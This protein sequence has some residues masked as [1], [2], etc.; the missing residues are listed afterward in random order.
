MVRAID[1]LETLG[2]GGISRGGYV[3]SKDCTK[4]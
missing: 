3:G 4:N 1:G 2:A